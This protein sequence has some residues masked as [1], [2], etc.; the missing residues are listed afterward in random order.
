MREY[1]IE[2]IFCTLVFKLADKA[3]PF[4]KHRT[5]LWWDYTNGIHNVFCDKHADINKGMKGECEL[6]RECE[7]E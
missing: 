7:D 3:C 5:D 6:F 2:D 4:C 1:E